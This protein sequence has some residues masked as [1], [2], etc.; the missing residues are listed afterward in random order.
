MELSGAFAVCRREF[1]RASAQQLE[2]LRT[3]MAGASL[4][5]ST[6][7]PVTAPGVSNGDGGN[8]TSQRGSGKPGG[9][10]SRGPA[11]AGQQQS[12]QSQLSTQP[13][14]TATTS[15]NTATSSGL[16]EPVQPL[17]PLPATATGPA[18]L[19]AMMAAVLAYYG[20]SCRRLSDTAA[21]A[22]SH[23][24]VTA[25]SA[26]FR[27]RL[28]SV[29]LGLPGDAVAGMLVEDGA[30]AAQRATLQERKDLL[31]HALRVMRAAG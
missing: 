28:T 1:G 23:H 21:M 6:L 15:T 12:Q 7:Q 25:F 4:S 20:L 17:L 13:L 18:E 26:R 30:C 9:P 14:C 5:G 8:D 31:E 24:L 11:I 2:G 27:S 19:L 29:M 10:D 16:Y 3:L 22:V